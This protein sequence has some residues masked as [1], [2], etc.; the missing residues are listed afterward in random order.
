[1]TTVY[2]SPDAMRPLD[3]QV[4]FDPTCE[5]CRRLATWLRREPTWIPVTLIASDDAGIQQRIGRAAP[6]GEELVVV[7]GWGHIWVGA[8]AFLV[9]LWATRRYRAWSYRLAGGA[10]A[11]LAQKWFDLLSSER[12]RISDMLEGQRRGGCSE[13]ACRSEHPLKADAAQLGGPR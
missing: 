10:L 3:L 11:P 13:G 1:M 8:D 12:R 6:I 4:I 5:L 9:A 7:D 2:R